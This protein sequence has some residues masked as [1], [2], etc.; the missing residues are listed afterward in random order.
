MFRC[1]GGGRKGRKEGEVRSRVQCCYYYYYYYY[2]YLQ[3]DKQA[4]VIKPN[5]NDG[6]INN[7][8]INYEFVR[9]KNNT[10]I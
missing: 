3:I 7:D 9:E 2:Y 5:D 1:S 8:D 10:Y 4:T 6:D